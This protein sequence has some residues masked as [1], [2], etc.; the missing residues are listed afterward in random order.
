M[1]KFARVGPFTRQPLHFLHAGPRPS[2]K[3]DFGWSSPRTFLASFPF[4]RMCRA[5]T[6]CKNP[7]VTEIT[8]TALGRLL[9]PLKR[10]QQILEMGVH[11]VWPP[12]EISYSR[13]R[14]GAHWLAPM[15]LPSPTLP[16]TRQRKPTSHHL[17]PPLHDINGL[18]TEDKFETK[19]HSR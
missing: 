2:S 5:L 10:L 11:R 16:I 6:Y 1:E 7:L 8:K 17:W 18:G 13:F 3:P 4:S 9:P 15:P 14:S 12:V 19:V